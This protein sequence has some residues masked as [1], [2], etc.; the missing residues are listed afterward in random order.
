MF[1]ELPEID[2]IRWM[3]IGVPVVI[4]FLPLTWFFLAY[5]GTPLK[6]FKIQNSKNVI[7]N[8]L[9]GLGKMNSGEKITLVV[10]VLTSLGWIFRKDIVIGRLNI[11][12]WAGLTG[13]S[14]YVNDATVAMAGAILLFII[15]VNLRKIDF[16]LNWDW[17]RRIPWGILILFGGGLALSKGFQESGLDIWIGTSFKN[18]SLNNPVVLILS[19]CLLLTFLTEITSNVAT[20][21]M[22]LPIL[23]AM[24]NPLGVNPLAIMIPATLSASCAFMMPVATPPN[25]IV[26]GSGFF[27]IQDMAKKGLILNFT[28]VIII[29]ALMY[30]VAF[31]LLGIVGFS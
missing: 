15:P 29:T 2:F 5:I 28:G 14:D 21:S 13:I 10:F 11:P 3:M 30:L 22:F 26:F 27:T 4:V 20:I 12:G 6:S 8:E 17:A 16:V 25:A 7:R 18:I 24:S 19:L 1:P 23:A 9:V 31:P